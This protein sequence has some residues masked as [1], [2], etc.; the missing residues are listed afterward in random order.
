MLKS[1]YPMRILHVFDHSL[2]L[3]SGYVSRSLSIIRSQQAR[4]WQTIQVTTPRYLP[5]AEKFEVVDG[6]KFYRS[7]R[8]GVSTF[9]VR[10]FLEIQATR[11]MLTDVIRQE[12]PDILHA[13]SPVLTVLPA[14]AAGRHFGLPVVYEVRAL[15]EDAAVDYGATT[16]GA[17]RYRA[18]RW[19]ETSAM[20]RADRVVTLCDPLRDEIIARGIPAANISVV[21]NAVDPEFLQPLID[22]QPDARER[23]GLNG[24]FVLGFIGSFYAYEGLDLLLAAVP[25][26]AEAIPGLLILLVGGGPEEDRLRRI[27]R[28]TGIESF[29]RFT[30]RV[31]HTQILTWYAAVDVMVFPRKRSRLTE[32]V[33]PLKPLEAMARGKPAIASDVG[34]HKQLIRDCDTGYLFAAEDQDAMIA[35][36]LEVARHGDD[37]SRVAANGRNFVESERTWRTVVD[38]YAVLY[39]QLLARTRRTEPGRLAA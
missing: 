27:V 10:E 11:R 8:V 7:A 31:H 20:H 6:L 38:R 2:P 14:I 17:L 37:R 21:P 28:E 15:W 23:L 32:L 18:S 16:E 9:V 3:Q 22:A 36:L 30:G 1:K 35:K 34:G 12:K 4:G 29:V 5:S 19:I 13:H 39:E 24:R 25:R 26:L 33:T